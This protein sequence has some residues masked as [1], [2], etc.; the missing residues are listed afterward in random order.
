MPNIR[1]LALPAE[2]LIPVDLARDGHGLVF[3]Q[4]FSTFSNRCLINAGKVMIFLPIFFTKIVSSF[5]YSEPF[6]ATN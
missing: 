3:S 5:I 1:K 2:C 6:T 4:R